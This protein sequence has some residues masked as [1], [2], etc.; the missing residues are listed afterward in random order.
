MKLFSITHDSLRITYGKLTEYE[1]MLQNGFSKKEAEKVLVLGLFNEL[2]Y[3]NARI[4]YRESG[5]PFLEHF[6]DKH[7]SISHAD[8]W[9]A[10][11]V[12]NLPIGIDIQSIRTRIGKGS[13]YFINEEEHQF[14]DNN[15][16]LHLIWCAKEAFYKLL[17]GNIADLR[18]EVSI[19]EINPQT[20]SIQLTY[21]GKEVVLH[22]I[23]LE[24]AYLVHT[25]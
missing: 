18:Q 20:S 16:Q 24:G 10:V 17:E 7:I 9:F 22:F 13:S 3:P 8:G 6:P 5:Q 21:F 23:P 11:G 14:Q 4:S 12:S 15:E 25:L 1:E 2:G 19:V